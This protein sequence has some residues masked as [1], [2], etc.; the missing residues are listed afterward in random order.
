MIVYV[1]ICFVIGELC[2]RMNVI[3]WCISWAFLQWVV[4]FKYG[5]CAV[6]FCCCK[7]SIFIR[8]VLC[9]IED[10]VTKTRTGAHLDPKKPMEWT[11]LT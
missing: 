5:G 8:I 3:A 10:F 9:K 4:K 1:Y 11:A 6:N 7:V 2:M